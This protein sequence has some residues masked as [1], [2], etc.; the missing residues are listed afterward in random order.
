MTGALFAAVA[1][2]AGA[3]QWNWHTPDLAASAQDRFWQGVW[4]P[5]YPLL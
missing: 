1:G 2:D 3:I 4:V 5:A